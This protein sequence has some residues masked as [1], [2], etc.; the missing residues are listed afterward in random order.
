[1][2][3]A[4]SQWLSVLSGLT[5]STQGGTDMKVFAVAEVSGLCANF[6]L[7]WRPPLPCSPSISLLANLVDMLLEIT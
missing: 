7:K 2:D 3:P 1:M 5:P 6:E 4:G